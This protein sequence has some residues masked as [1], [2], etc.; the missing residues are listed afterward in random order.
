MY[1]VSATQTLTG[2]PGAPPPFQLPVRIFSI[3]GP[4]FFID[5]SIVQTVYP[6]VG[7]SDQY[8]P[9]IPF[10]VFTDPSLPWE[11]SLTPNGPA[12]LAGN[13]T[14]WLALVIFAEGEIIMPVD[15]HGNVMSNN[16]TTA[17]T[18]AQ[19]LATDSTTLKP[20]LPPN[21][22]SADVLASTCQTITIPASVFANV[23]PTESDLVYLA[24][25][26]G[27]NTLTE[28]EHLLSVLLCNRLPL[29]SATPV[30]YYAHVVSLEGYAPY[31]NPGTPIPSNFEY[32]QLASLYNWTFV[33]QP[34][35]GQSFGQLMSGLIQSENGTM[36]ALQL[37]VTAGMNLPQ[38]VADRLNAGYAPLTFV[39]GSGEET[40]AWYRGPLSPLVPAPLPNLSNP[41]V[42]VLQAGGADEL[43]IYVQDQG[44]FDLSYASAW[45]IGRSVALADAGFVHKLSHYRH[46]AK[47]QLN[48]LA[49]RMAMAH[50][51]DEFSVRQLLAVNASRQKFATRM[52]EGLGKNWTQSLAGV[53]GTE[54]PRSNSIH[55]G[56]RYQRR[57]TIHPRD[58]LAQPDVPAALSENI[59]DTSK[60]LSKWLKELT[61]L[62]PL[63]F[64]HLVAQPA[65][66]PPESIR[67]F[68]LDPNWLQAMTAGAMSIAMQNTDDASLF[69]SLLPSFTAT[70]GGL[71]SGMLI[72]SQLIAAWPELVVTASSGG[73]PM[74]ILRIDTLSPN[75]KIV[76]FDGIPDTVSLTE[77]YKGLLFGTQ[78]NSI[79]PRCVT[80][81]TTAGGLI[82]NVAP[83]APLYRATAG[84]LDVTATAAALQNATGVVPFTTA[85]VVMWNT[86][87]LATTYVGPNQLTAIVPA[88]YVA[89]SG[90]A[91]ITVTTGSTTSQ[92]VDFLIQKPFAINALNPALIVNDAHDFELTVVGIG[93]TV[94]AFVQWNDTKLN[95][96]V[97]NVNTA[98]ATVPAHLT[99]AVEQATIVV[100][101]NGISSNSLPF[102]VVGGAP[103]INALQPSICNTG[104]TG[105]TLTVAGFGFT[106]A[107]TIQWGTTTLPTTFISEQQLT[108]PIRTDM[109]TT[110]G[111]IGIAVMFNGTASQ[112]V[113]FTISTLA[114]QINAIQ[115]MVAM[116]DGVAFTLTVTG[117]NF[118]TDAQ[119]QWN[120][121]P[122]ATTRVSAT[123]LTASVTPQQLATAGPMPITVYALGTSNAVI[124]N[125]VPT[126]SCIGLLEPPSVVAGVSQEFVLTVTG[127]LGAG[128][129][130]LQL[131]AMP[132]VQSFLS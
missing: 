84:V 18:V 88:N 21:F 52:S 14:P 103:V 100:V 57:R 11:R 30:R 36:G 102:Q 59:G 120:G 123:Q 75:V 107:A 85:S 43:I 32:V 72:R 46:T 109:L 94:D 20:T 97:V 15:Q 10:V 60:A 27:V 83:V 112:P 6:P 82:G 38:N 111:S 61:L 37:P 89:N 45:N 92:P 81:P 3:Q 116:K 34:V 49:Q 53:R 130:A 33:S 115:P 71:R 62:Y 70:D 12:S 47:L 9:N 2:S 7:G 22:V 124:C 98:I 126:A 68:Y 25:C 44:I 55:R 42:P 56:P 122:L 110:A 106:P 73:A 99:K 90:S 118:S 87:T 95:T 40:F 108:A 86:A 80:D 54:T 121:T 119:V 101:A 50:F 1:C 13:S 131:V 35:P 79:T 29:S 67:F 28:G 39:A 113:T 77:P 63:P 58:V 48:L 19:F 24:H 114:V 16:P 8:G 41:P 31:L 117:E 74:S 93:F 91:A 23:M 17:R 66:L 125:V 51:A 128:N 105:F 76:L 64:A 4:E 26:R 129:F 104:A 5:P 78:A 96:T 65:M 132:Q 69:N 127:G